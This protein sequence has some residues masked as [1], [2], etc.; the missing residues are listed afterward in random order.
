MLDVA[1]DGAC[2]RCGRDK[3]LLHQFAVDLFGV[4]PGKCLLEP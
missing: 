1:L 2:V 3:G 4:D